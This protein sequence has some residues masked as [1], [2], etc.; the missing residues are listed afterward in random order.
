MEWIVEV[1]GEYRGAC[2]API[3]GLHEIVIR[4][5]R[6]GEPLGEDR[7]N[8]QATELTNELFGAAMNRALLARGACL[9]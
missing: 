2:V 5:E 3:E 1:D 4:A 8:G 6:N 9:L 7:I